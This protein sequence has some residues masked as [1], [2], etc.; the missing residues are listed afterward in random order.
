MGYMDMVS[1]LCTF[2]FLFMCV[3]MCM[4]YLFV[5]REG[6][7]F[8]SRVHENVSNLKKRASDVTATR[9]RERETIHRY[10]FIVQHHVIVM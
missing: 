7:E 4:F 10:C 6:R 8:Y 5:Y 1:Y 2:S 9:S 3:H